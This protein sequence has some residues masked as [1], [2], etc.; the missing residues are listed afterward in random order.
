MKEPEPETMDRWAWD[1]ILCATLD[2]KFTPK[3]VPQRSKA[4]A[5][6]RRL[7]EPGRPPELRIV[8]KAEKSR[9]MSAPSGRA[10][11]L[12]TFLHHEIHAAELI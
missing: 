11:A 9:G 3:A 4:D 8:R 7:L 6:A 1:Y 2:E 5:P 12:H 10:R